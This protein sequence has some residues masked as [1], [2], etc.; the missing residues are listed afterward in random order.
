M[1]AVFSYVNLDGKLGSFLATSQGERETV[2]PANLWSLAGEQH[3][4]REKPPERYGFLNIAKINS[5][6][7]N[8]TPKRVILID[9]ELNNCHVL[10]YIEKSHKMYIMNS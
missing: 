9:E 6:M 7:W 1:K 5:L 2:L 8:A 4:Y 3:L 10:K